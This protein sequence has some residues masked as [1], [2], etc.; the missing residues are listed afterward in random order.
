MENLKINKNMFLI[1][2][3]KRNDVNECV[4]TITTKT[5]PMIQN[6]KI[7]KRKKHYYIL[8]CNSLF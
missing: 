3:S 8:K 5:Q 7:T 6:K 1:E 4:E 2:V